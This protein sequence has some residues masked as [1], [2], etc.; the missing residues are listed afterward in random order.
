MAKRITTSGKSPKPRSSGPEL[1]LDL[2]PPGTLT[3]VASKTSAPTTSEDTLNAI[4]SLASE[5]GPS[6]LG[7][8]DGPTTARSGVRAAHASLSARQAKAL[9]LMTSVTYGHLCIGSSSSSALQ[10]SL[11]SRLRDRGR[12]DGSTLYKLTWKIWR[13]P[14]GPSRSQLRASDLRKRGTGSTGWPTPKKGKSGG[15][16]NPNRG[17]QRRIEDT[18]T[19]IALTGPGMLGSSAAMAKD[20]RLNVEHSRWLM[21]Y[22]D[23]WT[24][25][26]P[27]ATPSSFPRQERSLERI[28][29]ITTHETDGWSEIVFTNS[30]FEKRLK[31]RLASFN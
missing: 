31:L 27:T 17:K 4:S 3:P 19:T 16:G 30:R 5:A 11:E 28:S 8:L 20:V 22:P 1:Q 21:G 15:R 9:G 12:I 18:A 2:F 7:K 10:S 13:T 25:T 26:Q 29:T 23:R 6:H 14:L 24:E